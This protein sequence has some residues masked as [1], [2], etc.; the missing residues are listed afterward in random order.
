MYYPREEKRDFLATL[1]TLALIAAIP[2]AILA[3]L[4][5]NGATYLFLMLGNEQTQANVIE[6]HS[7]SPYQAF[8]KYEYQVGDSSFISDYA[9]NR[10]QDRVGYVTNGP[11][12]IVHSTL[13]PSIE[14]TLATY[15]TNRADAKIFAGCVIGIALLLALSFFALTR[16]IKHANEDFYY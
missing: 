2:L 7:T 14:L 13:L 4:S 1:S 6:V 12:P 5:N 3:L 16:Q 15:K 11:I 8:I 10:Q 9:Q